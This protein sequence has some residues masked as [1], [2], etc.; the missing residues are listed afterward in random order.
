MDSHDFKESVK[1]VSLGEQYHEPVG[2]DL[3]GHPH[4]G[5]CIDPVFQRLLVKEIILVNRPL[6]LDISP[7]TADDLAKR[8][9]EKLSE[10]RQG[11]I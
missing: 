10:Y 11:E 9:V 1:S 7:D 4:L 3:R 2:C 5:A 8:I 6:G